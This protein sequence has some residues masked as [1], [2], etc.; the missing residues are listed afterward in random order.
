MT[1]VP[2][3]HP[4]ERVFTDLVGPIKTVSLG[5][6]RYFVTMFGKRYGYMAIKFSK[7]NPEAPVAVI[8]AFD[9]SKSLCSNNVKNRDNFY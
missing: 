3:S 4:I 5:G 2:S 8:A 6:L 7:F 1:N 9:A